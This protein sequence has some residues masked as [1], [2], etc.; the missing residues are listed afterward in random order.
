[1]SLSVVSF[2]LLF[3]SSSS[4]IIQVKEGDLIPA[5]KTPRCLESEVPYPGGVCAQFDDAFATAYKFL[6]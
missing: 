5:K 3:H 1:M 4:V 6:E 2:M